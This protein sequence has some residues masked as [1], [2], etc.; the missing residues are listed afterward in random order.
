MKSQRKIISA[1]LSFVISFL[2]IAPSLSILAAAADTST[3]SDNTWAWNQ[4]T[5]RLNID[6]RGYLSQH[7]LVYKSLPLDGEKEGMPIANGSTGAQV[8][9]DDGI[10]MQIHSVDNA[11]NSAFSAAQVRL[12]TTPTL[13]DS[14]GFEQRLNLYDG[15]ISVDQND[16]FTA[17]IF[18]LPNSEILGIHVKDDRSD[19]QSITFDI[20]MW[21]ASDNAINTS[22]TEDLNA[23][24]T[25]KYFENNGVVGFTKGISAKEPFGY[26]FA[27][28]VDGADF[29]I[30]KLDDLTARITITMPENGEYT[31][32]M[33]SSS[34]CY[35]ELDNIADAYGETPNYTSTAEDIF[36]K[37]TSELNNAKVIGYTAGIDS[38]KNWWNEYWQRSFVQYDNGNENE[39]DYHENLYYISL[40]HI[41]GAAFA[42]YQQ[43][44]FMNGVYNALKD[45][46]I[47]WNEGFWHF[48][49]RAV[50]QGLMASNHVDGY[51]SYL[52]FYDQIKDSMT[53]F[54]VSEYNEI[55]NPSRGFITNGVTDA[56]N[57]A[58]TV[59][60]DG[61]SGDISLVG[62]S[63][64]TMYRSPY[65][66]WIFSTGFEVA[67]NMYSAYQ[68]TMDEELLAKYYEYIRRTVQ[69]IVQWA[70]KDESGLYQ[71]DYSNAME[72]WW[73]INNASQANA[74][75][76]SLIPKFIDAANVLGKN[77]VDAELIAQAKDVLEYL[78]P[79]TTVTENGE[80]RFMAY[81]IYD[82][83][84]DIYPGGV[85]K[86][87]FQQPEL[88]LV[89]PHN[90]IG[91]DSDP[92]LYAMAMNNYKTRSKNSTTIYC[93]NVDGIYAARLGL[94]NDANKHLGDMISLKQMRISG[95]TDDGNGELEPMG[96][97]IS[98]INEMLLQSYDGVIRVFPAVPDNFSGAFTLLAN[99]GFLVSSECENSTAKY[100][101]IKSQYGGN[102]TV[103]IPW[104]DS[105]VLVNGVETD[106]IDGRIVVETEKNGVYIIRPKSSADVKYTAVAFTGEANNSTKTAFNKTLGIAQSVGDDSRVDINLNF[107]DSN[108]DG[109]FTNVNG[110][111]NA[112]IK[113]TVGW[114]EKSGYIAG[115]EYYASFGGNGYLEIAHD[116]KSFNPSKNFV[117]SFDMKTDSTANM[118]IFDKYGSNTE[119][120][121]YID[122]YQ[123]A[124][125]I[126]VNNKLT[127]V[128]IKTAGA[129]PLCDG[130][131]HNVRVVVNTDESTLSVYLDGEKKAGNTID[132]KFVTS[133]TQNARIAANREAKQN[134]IGLLDNFMIVPISAPYEIYYDFEDSVAD[135]MFDDT[136]GN[137]TANVVGTVTTESY[138][139]GNAVYFGGN[140]SHLEIEGSDSIT[141]MEDFEVSFDMKTD[142]KGNMCLFDKYGP[143]TIGSL[144]IDIHTNKFRVIANRKDWGIPMGDES[145]IEL[146]DGQWHNVRVSVNTSEYTISVY[147]DGTLYGTTEILDGVIVGTEQIARI[148]CDRNGKSSYIGLLDNFKISN[149]KET[150]SYEVS[151]DF[152][153]K[154]ADGD[155]EDSVADYDA[156][157]VGSGVTTEARGE[158]YA[159]SLNGGYLELK[160]SDT[161]GVMENFVLSFD[162]KTDTT[163]NVCLFDKYG[164]NS[165]GSLYVDIHTNKFRVII[166]QQDWGVPID[167]DGA[168][169]LRDGNWHNV[170]IE[171]DTANSTVKVYFDEQLHGSTSITGSV[172]AA[173][174][175]LA[176]I[177]A[178]RNGRSSFIGS[179]D[180]FSISSL[181]V[182]VSK[183]TINKTSVTL[184]ESGGEKLKA[185]I[186]PSDATDKAVIWSSS[187]ED[188][189][190]VDRV[191]R[192][193]AKAIG[194]A[195]VTVK[196]IDG[197]VEATCKVV[198]ECAH[199]LSEYK[200]AA[201]G[202]HYRECLKSECEYVTETT[203]C[204]GAGAGC[205]S[206]D[207][208][209]LCNQFL[210]VAAGHKEETVEAR[211]PTCSKVGLT[212]GKRCSVCGEVLV[213]QEE[214]PTLDH[215]YASDCDESCSSCSATR[216]PL[217]EH[218]GGKATCQAKARCE[219]CDAEYGELAQHSATT[220]WRT[221]ETHHYH[222]CIYWTE[223]G[224]CQERLDYAEHADTDS[225]GKC[226]ICDYAMST[227]TVEPDTDTEPGTDPVDPDNDASGDD[228]GLGIGAVVAIIV[229][230]VAVIGGGSFAIFWLLFL[231]IHFALNNM[232]TQLNSN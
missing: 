118:C 23:W 176:R 115:S 190:V 95:Y 217:A 205:I 33:N 229:S 6:Y 125:R 140:G 111:N 141:M 62:Q 18:G 230:S 29:S 12:S 181:P 19:V 58:E 137:Y 224:S 156:T 200:P 30:S 195:I 169:A 39:S 14:Q 197:S 185:E 44:H 168:F 26:A 202:K 139:N 213:A 16:G 149:I 232:H 99:G 34:R 80:T 219:V 226:D 127:S 150:P 129:F 198:V 17:K 76:R 164:V 207:H 8:W 142:S 123:N 88:E 188:V 160:D 148:G 121:L 78:E 4:T 189:V 107:N 122:I 66:L 145:G 96:L 163:G 126:F 204:I 52:N 167:V 56:M 91:V 110:S 173:T 100:I 71:I 81:D 59:R 208:C 27:A 61:Y 86:N 147:F 5:G 57:T 45:E 158:G 193:T 74:G 79:I 41:G 11:P 84:S 131:W 3:Q 89:Y 119:G 206:D 159:V 85:K 20:E 201:D 151:I 103:K 157:I 153:N 1:V 49:Q 94:G 40:Y 70:E 68:Y 51:L 214:I 124:L 32:W 37:A 47:R 172:V 220:E 83:Y 191:G 166:N 82:D 135:E 177:G 199:Q 75:I 53:T 231:E 112:S 117:V 21:R 109:I 178:D 182:S 72:N 2:C 10:R 132:E 46:D 64:S 138:E 54:T 215:V 120:S 67:E 209:L 73:R 7:D 144:Y 192:I 180:N 154:T 9:Q 183:I 227:G 128:P 184:S 77:S 225:N 221:N 48:N 24:K 106:V 130:N 55:N 63:D 35:L 175:Q 98:T 194:E 179:I 216:T 13:D 203:E 113:G 60:W 228:D 15:Y 134:Y 69:F 165:I 93:W 222:L 25:V 174:D 114:K 87:N 104:S 170:K 108:S 38:F 28:T 31:I 116:D 65:I 196:T 186:Y 218:S 92:E 105:T 90:L 101:G 162:L 223:G 22:G 171:V 42:K 187:N 50:Y 212:E 102:A 36:N 210:S 152:D 133:N 143:N 43:M 136:V 155:F 146:R 97:H 211:E 161:F